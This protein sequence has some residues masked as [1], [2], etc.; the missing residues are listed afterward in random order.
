[1]KYVY[2]AGPITGVSYDDTVN[3]RQRVSDAFLPG[4]VG[5][6]PMRVKEFLA[7]EKAIGHSYPEHEI[8]GAA[9][10]I[11]TRDFYD[12][13][14][15]DMVLAYLPM[16]A[17][18]KSGSVSVG[19]CM[20]LGW[21]SGAGNPLVVVSDD[22]MVTTHPLV[23]GKAGWIVPRLEDGVAAVNAVLGIYVEYGPPIVVQGWGG[24]ARREAA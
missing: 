13:T 24:P 11:C 6:S 12:C 16:W 9:V 1:M 21:A 3:W 5:V 19:T 7:A 14:H 22:P 15:A 4:I 23:Q 18:S 2:L 20:E 17:R 10:P 8:M